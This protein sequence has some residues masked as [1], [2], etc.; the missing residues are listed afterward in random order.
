[1][2]VRKLRQCLSMAC[3]LNRSPY[4]EDMSE[5]L[6]ARAGVESDRMRQAS[7]RIALALRH[8]GLLPQPT[9]QLLAV[10]GNFDHTGMAQEWY[11]WCMSWYEQAADLTPGVRA[12]YTSLLLAVGRW[13]QEQHPEI[14]TPEQWTEELAF[15]FRS[16]LCSWTTGQYVGDFARRTLKT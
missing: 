13:L 15:R 9:K 7:Q 1:T 11:Q 4:L 16:D 5:E 3:V 8:L 2:T 12:Q 10:R 14:H 6:L